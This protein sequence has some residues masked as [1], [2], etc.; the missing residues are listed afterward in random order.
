MP[1]TLTK[2]ESE[3][4]EQA[5]LQRIE[6]IRNKMLGD[7]DENGI[8]QI[9]SRM[10]KE[11]LSMR[12][13]LIERYDTQCLIESET[14]YDKRLYFSLKVEDNLV[15][16]SVLEKMRYGTNLEHK[17]PYC[18]IR[19]TTLEQLI[20]ERKPKNL[21]ELLFKRYNIHIAEK[22]DSLDVKD[23]SP[24]EIEQYFST[25]DRK[26]M[27][28]EKE[29]ELKSKEQLLDEIEKEYYLDTIQALKKS[30]SYGKQ[31]I[32]D[33]E[34]RMITVRPFI[35]PKRPGYYKSLNQILGTIIQADRTEENKSEVQLFEAKIDSSRR[36]YANDL[37]KVIP[38]LPAPV[39]DEGLRQQ[40]VDE[41]TIAITS[42]QSNEVK[43][44]QQERAKRDAA[45]KAVPARPETKTAPKTEAKQGKEE[46]K[47]EPVVVKKEDKKEVK[48]APKTEVKKNI[49][50]TP[51]PENK[52][53]EELAKK[54]AVKPIVKEPET[55]KTPKVSKAFEEI[56]GGEEEKSLVEQVKINYEVYTGESRSHSNGQENLTKDDP[57]KKLSDKKGQN[58][59]KRIV[60]NYV[61]PDDHNYEQIGVA[62]KKRYSEEKGESIH[63]R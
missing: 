40:K 22:P 39:T 63:R 50:I 11:L 6:V 5:V 57:A 16:F 15:T 59:N 53:A 37:S 19:T 49:P 24:A 29:K 26:L 46:V 47:K 36:K 27:I 34:Q 45:E 1:N 14:V 55:P 3:A 41:L 38:V 2:S 32:S 21:E 7:F 8:Y 52:P 42:A 4:F 25:I 18:N 48:P 23:M 10:A 30:G 9:N 56:T 44:K 58:P 43:A 28:E 17:S 35:D 33:M 60:L 12:K 51:K 13:Y 31:V 62:Y 61:P 20:L 54:V